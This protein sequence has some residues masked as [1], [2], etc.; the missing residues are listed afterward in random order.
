MNATAASPP[1]SSAVD[2]S[3]QSTADPAVF[4]ANLGYNISEQFENMY[5]LTGTLPVI[6]FGNG[7]TVAAAAATAAAAAPAS[8]GSQPSGSQPSAEVLAWE[9]LDALRLQESGSSLAAGSKDLSEPRHDHMPPGERGRHFGS[10][11]LK[12][13]IALRASTAAPTLFKPLFMDGE[14]FTDGGVVCSNPAAIA[15]HEADSLFPTVGVE[16]LVSCGTGSFVEERLTPRIGWVSGR[17]ESEE[18]L[19]GE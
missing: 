9:S 5:S 14:F 7:T 16:L 15:L 18:W 11:R 1:A 2:Y 8:A 19:R 10:M 13:R 4:F 17:W 3:K 6:N 12:Q